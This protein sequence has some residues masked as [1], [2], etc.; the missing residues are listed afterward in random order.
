MGGE[1]DPFRDA[2]VGPIASRALT[3][4]AM[5]GV[6]DSLAESPA[7]PAELAERLSLD[8]L[9][10]EGL[11]GALAAMGYLDMEDGRFRPTPV[12][13]RQLVRGSPESIA[14]FVGAQGELHWEVL[15]ILPE[16]IRSGQAYGMHEQRLDSGHWE[17]YIRG[18]HEI[19]RAEHDAN[20]SLVPV[21]EPRRL[22][23]VAGGH[24]A[25]A[26]AMCR[27]HPSLQ[28]TVIELPPAAAVGWR[29]VK[30]EGYAD[31]VDFREGDVFQV[32]LG[33]DV[34]VISAFNLAHH[35]S[36]DRNRQLCRMAREALRPGGAMVLGDT[37]RPKPGEDVSQHGALSGLLFYAWSHGRNFTR[38]EIASWLTEAGFTGVDV[39]RNERSPWRIVVVARA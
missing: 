28:A 12:A 27:R 22:V 2:F 30:E 6:F 8:P 5:L 26:M 18:L 34:D 7:A 21:D 24:G 19:S 1:P 36:A 9:G 4:A 11:L 39:H 32:G 31:R 15:T 29:I 14:T 38:T 33:Q 23:D 17:G 20:A 37:E 13:R 35:L 25:F 16:A 3:T 10:A